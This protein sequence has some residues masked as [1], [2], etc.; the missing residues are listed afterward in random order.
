MLTSVHVAIKEMGLGA[1]GGATVD[2]GAEDPF[3]EGAA[4]QYLR[5]VSL[6]QRP[7]IGCARYGR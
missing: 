4:M 1:G 3:K 7:G 2:A 6:S 5:G